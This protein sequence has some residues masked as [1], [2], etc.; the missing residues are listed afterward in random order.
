L[1]QKGTILPLSLDLERLAPSVSKPR[2]CNFSL[3]LRRKQQQ[4]GT[5]TTT[6]RQ[7]AMSH[8]S[9]IGA[10]AQPE[11]RLQWI[12]HVAEAY[13]KCQRPM[14]GIHH[15]HRRTLTP[16]SWD[17]QATMGILFQCALLGEGGEFVIL[18]DDYAEESIRRVSKPPSPLETNS[19]HHPIL[20]QK[21]LL[22]H[23]FLPKVTRALKTKTA[24]DNRHVVRRIA[25]LAMS[26]IGALERHGCSA[27]PAMEC[28]TFALLWRL[29]DAQTLMA[30]IKSRA[31]TRKCL[32]SNATRSSVQTPFMGTQC[33]AVLLMVVVQHVPFGSLSTDTVIARN[34]QPGTRLG[35]LASRLSH[36]T[37]ASYKPLLNSPDTVATLRNRT[38]QLSLTM[39]SSPTDYRLPS[40]LI[41]M[42][43]THDRL[44]EAVRVGSTLVDSVDDM[45]QTTRAAV[46]YAR[47]H[48]N[49]QDFL[50]VVRRRWTRDINATK[51]DRCRL[52]QS[53]HSFL[54]QWDPQCIRGLS[55]ST[56]V[57]LH[58]ETGKDDLDGT[59]SIPAWRRRLSRRP[60]FVPTMYT[61]SKKAGGHIS[62][63]FPKTIALDTVTIPK[64]HSS[65][66]AYFEQVFRIR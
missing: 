47:R 51:S 8:F 35:S 40:S 63:P 30:L 4:S 45:N 12:D 33:H 3:L 34:N 14:T 20:F 60:S 46:I 22:E 16:L 42:L 31:W 11:Q 57:V 2:R 59:T 55:A 5:T 62:S 48:N 21:D 13:S 32:R 38:L 43:L 29:G 39:I 18:G 28:F 1:T 64:E 61:G 54:S 53:I 23:L 7:I 24:A 6:G 27:C 19:C 9:A 10:L 25:E 52:L 66:Q 36:E 50:E 26:Y 17:M 56:H 44:S 15:H 37:Q 58:T 65:F 41:S 49:G